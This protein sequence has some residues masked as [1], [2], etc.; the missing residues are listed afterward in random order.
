MKK[1]FL[2]PASKPVYYRHKHSSFNPFKRK[3]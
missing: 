2:D 3:L 1:V